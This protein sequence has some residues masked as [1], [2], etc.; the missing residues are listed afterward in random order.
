[1]SSLPRPTIAN[2]KA[3]VRAFFD[4]LASR[5][6]DRHGPARARLRYR[7]G[8]L[9]RHAQFRPSDVVLDLGCGPGA[10]L[11]ALAPRIDR[12]VGVDLSPEMVR[13]ARRRTSAPGLSFRVDDATELATVPTGSVDKVICVGVLEHLLRPAQALRQ[14]ARV[15]RPDGRFVAL[16]LNGTYWWYRLADRLGLPTRHLTTDRRLTPPQACKL[17]RRHD[18]SPTVG[19]WRFVPGDDLPSPVASLCRVLDVIGRHVA[20][21]SLRGGLWLRGILS[22]ADAARPTGARS[23]RHVPSTG[24]R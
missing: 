19:F 16:T 12:G 6:E 24:A 17:L 14:V 20:P 21:S 22:G 4:G 15:L 18:F 2:S 9:D 1:V 23:G 3:D 7:V 10:H 13:T 5:Y 11:R 8:L